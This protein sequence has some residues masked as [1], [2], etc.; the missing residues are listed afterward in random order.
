[1]NPV[2]NVVS[3]IRATGRLH[4]GNYLGVLKRFAEMSRNTDLN[5]FFFVADLHTLT[6]LK[7]AQLIKD[8]INDIILD[9]LAAGVDYNRATI[10][11]QSAVPSVTELNWYLSCLTLV[12]ELTGQPSFKQK[13]DQRPE[14]INA[15][16]LTYPVL[17]AAD[18]LGPHAH[19][20]PVGKDQLPHLELA[21]D[22]ARR[23]N[24]EYGEEYFPI[25]DAM[26]EEAITVPGLSLK[27]ETG[28]PKMGKS[29]DNTIDLVASSEDVRKRLAVAPTDPQRSLKSI[30]GNPDNCAI[31]QLHK[32]MST[33][34]EIACADQGCR[35]A[36]IG[37]VECKA[38]LARSVDRTLG[39]FRDLR[40]DL[41]RQS[42]L[43]SDILETGRRKAEAVFA[44]TIGHVREK[45]GIDY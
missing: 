1:M 12:T 2:A 19:Y 39:P 15:G 11:V 31:F 40:A 41:A 4:L 3:G 23:F 29:D 33:K 22:V 7:E 44:E 38:I 10:Y 28:F 42:N 18:I 17:M 27:G 9:Y 14:D 21:R 26:R 5:C 6:T 25:P 45:M 8:F 30:P 24:R 37:C 43:V 16:L 13:S 35:T 32:L 20:V 34:D 36:G